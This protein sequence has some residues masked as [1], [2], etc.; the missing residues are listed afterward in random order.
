MAADGARLSREA[1]RVCAYWAATTAGHMVRRRQL[2]GA[3]AQSREALRTSRSPAF[4]LR[5][6]GMLLHAGAALMLRAVRGV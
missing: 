2:S 5:V 4:C 1:Y 3:W 6:L